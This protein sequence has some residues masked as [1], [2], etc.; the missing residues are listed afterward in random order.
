MF[1]YVLD[2]QNVH[3]RKVAVEVRTNENFSRFRSS[4]RCYPVSRTLDR[5]NDFDNAGRFTSACS[6]IV[7]RDDLF[8]E[9]FADN[10]F[11][12]EPVHNL[13]HRQI[14]TPDGETFTSRR[15]DDERESEFLASRDNWFRPTMLKV[16]PDG[17]LYIADMYRAV[18]EHVQYIPRELQKGLDVR[19]GDK[20]G[21]IYRVFPRA[22][23]PR[24]VPRYDRM[25]TKEL[26]GALDSASGWQR[27]MAQRLLVLR[28]DKSAG[29]ASNKWFS[30]VRGRRHACTRCARCR[31][32]A[33]L[34]RPLC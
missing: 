30:R 34:L 21:R 8:G 33:C 7:Y 13:V 23:P 29:P 25:N 15:A 1:H 12:S 20:Q 27:D 10:W 11:V 14:L 3:G 4:P 31:D 5:F 22:T 2:A 32:W 16:G 18:I 9:E 19:A 6:A 24:S 17:A 28:D 26:V